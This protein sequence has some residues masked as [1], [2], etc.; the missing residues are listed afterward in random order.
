[1][2]KKEKGL[3]KGYL[4]YYEIHFIMATDVVKRDGSKQPFDEGKIRRSIELACQ[5]AG[6]GPEKTAEVVNQVLPQV[7][8]TAGSKEEIATSEL[9]EAVLAGLDVADSAAAEAWRA[10]VQNKGA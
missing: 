4:H 1:M 9:A 8:E 6:V 2:L 10:Y 5:D 3:N 7:L